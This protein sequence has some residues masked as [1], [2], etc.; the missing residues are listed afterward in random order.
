MILI[1]SEVLFMLANA[2]LNEHSLQKLKLLK[3]TIRS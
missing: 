1:F 3:N 2:R